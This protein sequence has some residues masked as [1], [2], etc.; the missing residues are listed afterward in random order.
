[1][2]VYVR[3]NGKLVD[4]ATLPRRPVDPAAFPTPRISRFEAFESPVTG[5]TI[6][7]W[8]ERERDMNENDCF[9]TRDLAPDHQW[10]RGREVQLKELEE[11]RA[12]GERSEFEW[13]DTPGD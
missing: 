1:M 5:E 10:R 7:S 13:R 12:N 9:D 11:V 6:S 3:R 8:R 4:V 2:T